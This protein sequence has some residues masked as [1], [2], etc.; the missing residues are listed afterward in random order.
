MTWFKVDDSLHSHPKARRAGL[1]AMGLWA[2]SGS[3]ASQYLTDGFVP[4]WFVASWPRGRQLAARL[5]DA[6]LWRAAER[7]GLPGWQFHEWDERNPSR[8][9]V[10]HDRAETR[11]RVAA[12]RERAQSDRNGGG[13]GV[14]ELVSNSVGTGAPTRPDPGTY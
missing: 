3:H 4:D 8:E 12:Y 9:K 11:Q 1:A 5:V 2:L 10:Q 13:N 7:D 6:D 14:T